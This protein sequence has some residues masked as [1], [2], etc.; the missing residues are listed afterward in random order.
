MLVIKDNEVSIIKSVVL[1]GSKHSGKAIHKDNKSYYEVLP[2]VS[3]LIQEA[4]LNKRI[5]RF[6]LIN[7]LLN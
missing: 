3:Q 2:E 1:I 6:P 7:R 5:P 4:L